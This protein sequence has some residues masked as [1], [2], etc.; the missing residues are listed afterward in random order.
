MKALR[1][2]PTR[3]IFIRDILLKIM[4]MR[5]SRVKQG[6]RKDQSKDEWMG[7]HHGQ[8]VF[9]PTRFSKETNAVCLR[10]VHL[11]REML[12]FISSFSPIVKCDL[13]DVNF[14]T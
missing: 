2:E 13:L 1:K 10:I 6:R 9:H 8:K 3:R 4:S 12:L 11:E 14:P 7:Y 5:D